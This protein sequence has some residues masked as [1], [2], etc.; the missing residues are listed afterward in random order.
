ME[1]YL[2]FYKTSV[3][4]QTYDATWARLHDPGE[5]MWLLGAYANGKLRGIVHTSITARAG[6]L[7][8]IAICRTCSSRK[9]RASSASAAR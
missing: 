8:T 4:Q 9:T 3:P 5:P 2:D 1:G 7:A 6:R